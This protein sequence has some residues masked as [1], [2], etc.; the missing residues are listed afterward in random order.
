MF[1]SG[2]L[3]RFNE[4]GVVLTLLN[5][6]CLAGIFQYVGC[7]FGWRANSRWVCRKN[8]GSSLLSFS[9]SNFYLI[10]RFQIYFNRL[11]KELQVILCNDCEK[12]GEATFHWLYH[13]C[14][15]CGSYN[16]RLLWFC[17]RVSGNNFFLKLLCVER[18]ACINNLDFTPWDWVKVLWET[19]NCTW[20]Y[21]N[22]IPFATCAL[23]I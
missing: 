17:F 20:D 19:S 23:I 12:R 4:I 14:S 11:W 16:T 5:S 10:Q 3:A 21:S 15:Y 18:W 7:I 6:E 22:K 2:I 8:S 9:Y 1:D 13:K